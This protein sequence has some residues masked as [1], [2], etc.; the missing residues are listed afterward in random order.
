MPKREHA[1][2]LRIR[3]LSFSPYVHLNALNKFI[4]AI[5]FSGLQ[6]PAPETYSTTTIPN[7]IIAYRVSFSSTYRFSDD[8]GWLSLSLSQSVVS[9][10]RLNVST[11][12][13]FVLRSLHTLAKFAASHMRSFSEI[14]V[15]YILGL[16]GSLDYHVIRFWSRFPA[17]PLNHFCWEF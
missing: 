17:V 12:G 10:N 8:I 4:L 16:F 6:L 3:L 13:A 11:G 14:W 15:I 7:H 2:R 5:I 9:Q 1:F